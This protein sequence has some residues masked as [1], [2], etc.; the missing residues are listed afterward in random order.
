[1]G[2]FYAS[3]RPMNPMNES[4]INPAVMSE[5]GAPRNGAGVLACSSLSR[6][7]A[8]RIMTSEKPTDALNP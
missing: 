2:I 4:D 3:V 7:A 6:K 1:M 5:I 8:N